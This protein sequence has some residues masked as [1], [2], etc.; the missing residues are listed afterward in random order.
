MER[1]R[2]PGTRQR[3]T[4]SSPAAQQR[5]G[6]ERGEGVGNERENNGWIAPRE[7]ERDSAAEEKHKCSSLLSPFPSTWS[8]WTPFPACGGTARGPKRRADDVAPGVRLTWR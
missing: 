6:E 5:G 8:T 7:R 1:E 3:R 4:S 2:N